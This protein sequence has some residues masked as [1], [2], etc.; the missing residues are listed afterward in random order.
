MKKLTRRHFLG[1]MG[2]GLLG[3]AA[4]SIGLEPVWLRVERV[5]MTLSRLAPSFDGYTIAQLSDLHVGSGVSLDFLREAVDA[6]NAARPDL[7]VVTGDLVDIAAKESA[8]S[9]LAGVLAGAQAK[10]GVLAVLGNHDTGSY[11]PG[12]PK[13]EDA[14]RRLTTS[15]QGVDVQLLRNDVHT[16]RRGKSR[17]HFVGLGDLWT[18]EFEP[19]IAVC[20]AC[21]VALS[22][23]PDTAPALAERDV[24]VVLSGHTHGGQVCIPLYGPPYL[25]Q[26]NKDLLAGRYDLDGT[27]LYV[28]AGLGWTHR[29]RFGARPEVTIVRLACG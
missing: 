27:Q 13:D 29:I 8:N 22:H 20:D 3:G 11:Y 2:V 14:I 18:S 26:R 9:E 10:D 12:E 24:D 4:Y 6:A 5:D 7:I 19:D 25:P 1:F 28:N 23:N 17:L 21:T 16:L 15:L